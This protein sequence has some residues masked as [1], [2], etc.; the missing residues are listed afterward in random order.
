MLNDVPRHSHPYKKHKR[1]T[2]WCLSCARSPG[3]PGHITCQHFPLLQCQQSPM[4][5]QPFSV[6][7]SCKGLF[8]SRSYALASCMP[9]DLAVPI[10]PTTCI[11]ASGVILD[12]FGMFCCGY[13]LGHG[14][15]NYEGPG[16]PATGYNMVVRTTDGSA[17]RNLLPFSLLAS[18]I[19][20]WFVHV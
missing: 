17:E 11:P 8:S 3:T 1:S 20:K 15:K 9:P 10:F 13:S 19:L 14:C 18:T 7:R 4:R 12:T 6:H 16:A 5:L 2:P